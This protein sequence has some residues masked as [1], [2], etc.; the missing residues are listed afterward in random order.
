MKAVID[1]DIIPVNKFTFN[2]VGLPPLTVTAVSGI[3]IETTMTKLPDNQQVT[4]GKSEPF[5]FTITMPENHRVE[6]IAMDLWWGGSKDPVSP[7]YRKAGVLIVKSNS[8][9]IAVAH[10][11]VK[12]WTRGPSFAE[13][14]LDDDGKISQVAWK[15]S[16]DKHEMLG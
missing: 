8:G 4:G 2:V 9:N 6:Q 1:P 5:E 13:R 3:E 12:L 11:F 10:S 7:T 14:D 15:M 16:A